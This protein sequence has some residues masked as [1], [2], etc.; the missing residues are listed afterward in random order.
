MAVKSMTGYGSAKCAVALGTINIELR[1]L[2]GKSLDLSLRCPSWCRPFEAQIRSMVTSGVLRGKTEMSISLSSEGKKEVAQINKEAFKAYY[3]EL[4]E[5]AQYASMPL[6]SERLLNTIMRMPDVMGEQ[7]LEL[8]EGDDAIILAATLEAIESHAAFRL[9]EGEVLL[10]DILSHINK[11]GEL[12]EVVPTFEGERIETVRTRL[13]ENLAKAEVTV[14][15]NRF[16]SEIIYYLEKYD[17]TE[18]KVRLAQHLTY[19]KEIATEGAEIGRKLGFIAQEIG[20]EVN[21]LGSKANH[22]EMQKLVIQMKDE[23][24][25]IKEQLLNIL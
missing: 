1:S 11:I 4:R 19:F 7:K 8:S 6:E 10:A 24:E 9:K 15:A 5:V 18:E 13:A 16:E 14:D 23:L 20:R 22:S 12:L 21:T 17:V 3:E 2:N 25:K